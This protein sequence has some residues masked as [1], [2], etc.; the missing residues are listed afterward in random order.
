MLEAGSLPTFYYL[1]P[2][3]FF[4]VGN[5]YRFW[6]QGRHIQDQLHS[7]SF[8]ICYHN[9]LEKIF[10]LFSWDR[11]WWQKILSF[12][13]KLF[14]PF[15]LARR[16]ACCLD[17]YLPQGFPKCLFIC[18]WKAYICSLKQREHTEQIHNQRSTFTI[19]P[20]SN[21]ISNSGIPQ[22]TVNMY[23]AVKRLKNHSFSCLREANSI[24]KCQVSTISE[25]VLSFCYFPNVINRCCTSDN[26][27]TLVNDLH[28][29]PNKSL[30]VGVDKFN[31][32]WQGRG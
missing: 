5:S 7:L 16:E 12:S 20:I 17:S 27:V 28:I 23:M 24:Q 4:T 6:V 30:S 8:W 31:W 9:W 25:V 13:T 2:K 14:S 29:L 11:F 3:G 15:Q 18:K 19:I 10:D 22:R 26:F 1:A 21:I 32:Y